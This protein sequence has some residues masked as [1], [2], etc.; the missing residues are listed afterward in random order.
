VP[1]VDAERIAPAVERLMMGLIRRRLGDM[2]PSPLTFTQHIALSHVVD[3]GPL[4]LR[5]MAERIGTTAATA[6]RST[7]ALESHGFVKRETDPCDGRGVLVRATRKGRQFR[8][9]TH[10]QLVILLERMLQQLDRD[11][12]GRFIALMT[13]LQSLVEASELRT[14]VTDAEPESVAREPVAG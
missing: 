11:D 5:D 10:E 3:D 9:D 1:Y 13:E 14:G 7:D 6:T 4:R 2:E 8:R 12:R